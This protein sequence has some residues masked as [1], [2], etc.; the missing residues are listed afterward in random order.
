VEVL[1]D[2]A[3]ETLRAGA[4]FCDDLS[5]ERRATVRARSRVRLLAVEKT[6]AAAVLAARPDVAARLSEPAVEPEM[7]ERP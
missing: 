7:T 6:A 4:L 2:G 3:S 1:T 5:T